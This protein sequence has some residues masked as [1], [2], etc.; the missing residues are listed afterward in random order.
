[1]SGIDIISPLGEEERASLINSIAGKIVARRLETP[2]V[3]FLEMHKPLSFIAS[4]TA[5]VTMPFFAPF[6]GAQGMAD[7]SKLLRD[8]ENIDR[9]ITRIEE[10]ANE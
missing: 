5:L 9:L 6:I 1:M 4:Q 10:L 7:F 2:V 3:L 8:R